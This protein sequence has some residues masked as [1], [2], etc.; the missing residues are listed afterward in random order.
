MPPQPFKIAVPDADL[1]DLRQRLA[2]TRW[3]EQVPSAPWSTGTDLLYLQRLADYWRTK[4]NWRAVEARVNAIPQY[5]ADV[6]GLR[7]HLLHLPGK[8]PKPVPLL[9]CHGWPGGVVELVDLACMLADP[10][11]H[12]GDPADAFD[13]VAP[14]LPGFGFSQAPGP[15]WDRFRLA[16]FWVSLMRSLGHERFAAHAYDVSAST[17]SLAAMRHPESFI[18][19]HT[20]EPGNPAPYLGDGARPLSSTEREYRAL[21][22][23][24]DADEGAYMAIAATRPQTIAYGLNDSPTGLAAWIVEKW[25]AWTD[26]SVPFEKRFSDDQILSNVAL[27]WFTQSINS[28]N[29]Y[30]YTSRRV[31]WCPRLSDRILVPTGVALTATQPIERAPREYASRI[32]AN[33]QRWEQ[34]PRGGHFVTMEEPA[35]LAQQIRAFLKPLRK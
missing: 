20:T 5:M 35:L 28:A 15:D 10:G 33:I 11:S 2:Q 21:S 8:G 7:V 17:V 26:P 3:P 16:D 31:P 25:F 34:M 30:Y 27:Y 1:D 23:R 24:W 9:L 6:D 29:A 4:F 12:G 22:E 32:Y 13:V 19:Y 14:S 18:G